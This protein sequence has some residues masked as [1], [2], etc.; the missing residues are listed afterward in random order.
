MKE[1]SCVSS[2]LG[3]SGAGIDINIA[4]MDPFAEYF[5]FPVICL[6]LKSTYAIIHFQLLFS[7]EDKAFHHKFHTLLKIPRSVKISNIHQNDK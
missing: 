2:I 3:G 5:Y 1:A 4:N 7:T 6:A